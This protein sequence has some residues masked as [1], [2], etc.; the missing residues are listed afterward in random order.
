[1]LTLSSQLDSNLIPHPR[2]YETRTLT[3][4]DLPVELMDRIFSYLRDE[5]LGTAA[6]VCVD[7][8][9]H[10]KTRRTSKLIAFRKLATFIY[11]NINSEIYSPQRKSLEPFI[12]LEKAGS[13]SK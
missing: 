1:M 6:R 4:N 8:N 5:E 13:S 11:K 7:W 2:S 9:V 12:N 3:Q 10:V